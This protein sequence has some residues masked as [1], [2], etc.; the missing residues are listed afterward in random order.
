MASSGLPSAI[1]RYVFSE[2]H[3]RITLAAVLV[4]TFVGA[5]FWFSVF[6]SQPA[7]KAIQDARQYLKF[8]YVSFLKPHTGDSHG[9]QQHALESF[10]AAQVCMAAMVFI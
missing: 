1:Q 3:V 4:F 9:G 8:F 6:K 10:Y 5:V 2:E 7:S